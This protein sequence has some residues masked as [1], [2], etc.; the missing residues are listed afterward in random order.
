MLVMA[1]GAAG[2]SL[3]RQVGER[4]TLSTWMPR[5]VSNRTIKLG[6]VE[7]AVVLRAVDLIEESWN[8]AWSTGFVDEGLSFKRDAFPGPPDLVA[9]LQE[10]YAVTLRERVQAALDR[11]ETSMEVVLQ[12]EEWELL[13]LLDRIAVVTKVSYGR[14]QLP[15]PPEL[16]LLDRLLQQRARTLVRQDRVV[17][18]SPRH[19]NGGALV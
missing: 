3:A 19:A 9:R 11:G 15:V 16:S 6:L 18:M 13:E 7:P 12:G 10:H 14:R 5:P 2:H 1:K 4:T 17:A 8:R